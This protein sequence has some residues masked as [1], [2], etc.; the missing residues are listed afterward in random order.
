VKIEVR[1]GKVIIDGYVNAVERFSRPLHD[2]RGTF[3]EK[4]MPGVFQKAIDKAKNILVL[5]NHDK[6]RQ[7]ADTESKTAKIHEDNIGMRANVEI[8]DAEVIK[9]A[10]AGK[11]RGWSFAF[12]C[13]NQT[14][15]KN[16]D[17]IEE[18]IITELELT[19]VSIIDDKKIPAYIATSIE[20][21]D[22]D[23]EIIEYRGGDF[24][25]NETSDNTLTASQKRELLSSEIKKSIDDSWLED[26]DDNNLY[27]RLDETCKLYKIPY[28]FTD[29][30]I[31]IDLDN[32]VE[33]IRGGYVE[34]GESPNLGQQSENRVDENYYENYKER[35]K[36][37][38]EEK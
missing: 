1:N 25:M 21:R 32:K 13:I 37:I 23:T 9:K 36:K 28:T 24:E 19:E 11:L 8:V 15:E 29:G 31:T 17:G 34:V 12:K 3:I 6:D 27:V 7:L 16:A 14:R 2:T 4:I 33:V 20:L 5:L 22:T 30:I 26:F 18:R 35:I 38:K 10:E